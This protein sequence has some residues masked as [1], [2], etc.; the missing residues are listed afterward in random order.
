MRKIR[1]CKS[2]RLNTGSSA[3]KIDWGKVKGAIL[4]EHGTKLPADIT[5]DKLTELCHADRPG[6]IYPIFPFLE[7]AKNGGEPQVNAVG[8][9][10]SQYNGL[11]AQTDTFTLKNF[12]EIL[13]AQLIKCAN[14]GW[15]VYF[16]NN[17]NI[18][19]GYN[20]GTDLLAGIPM[21]TV[22]P[23]VT[24]YPTSGA[25]STM[26]VS[27]CHEDAEDSQLNFNFE[28]LDF[29]PKN[30]LK[31][32][33]DV[34][35]EKTSTENAYKIIEKI[36]NYDRT[37]EFGSLVADGAA[38]IMNNVTSATYADGVITIVPKAGAVPSLKAP[39]VLFEKG[40]KGIEQVA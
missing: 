14:K 25:K 28:Q 35:F 27:F 3:C 40:I 30:F 26:T 29:N 10:A 21:S 19:I 24:Q 32:L 11:N 22:Y 15:D 20:D 8:Y 17:D 13:N 31:G 5:G 12:D 37:E 2:A 9:G 16:W 4:T 18:L 34:V 33:V 23:T 36:G 7:Y 1:T 38:E 39:S 6:R